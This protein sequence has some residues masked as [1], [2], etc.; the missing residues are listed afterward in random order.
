MQNFIAFH[1]G[2]VDDSPAVPAAAEDFRRAEAILQ[3]YFSRR[4]TFS[5]REYNSKNR[6]AFLSWLGGR[7]NT[8]KE[9]LVL[10]LAAE[11]SLSG[12][13]I[14]EFLQLGRSTVQNIIKKQ[15]SGQ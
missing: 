11:T 4:Y 9:E 6:Q 13:Q 7:G 14:A 5:Q 10:Q 12:R 2:V 1:K 8:L 15:R 3:Q